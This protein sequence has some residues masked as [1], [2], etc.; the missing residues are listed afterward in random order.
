MIKKPSRKRSESTPLGEN[1][2][3]IM[4]ERNLSMRV[5]AGMA[6]V[7]V[8]SISD[9]VNNSSPADLQKVAALAKGLNIS[10]SFLVL[11]VHEESKTD[12]LTIDDLYDSEGT[13]LEGVFR[14]SAV[15]LIKKQRK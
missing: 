5:L 6:G 7:S 3:R 2:K 11:G 13:P 1:L 9:W 14:I 15:R 10:F 12:K 8:S 4:K